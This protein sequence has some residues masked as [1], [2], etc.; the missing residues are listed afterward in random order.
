MN[1]QAIE[2][3]FREGF[4]AGMRFRA[5]SEVG[6]RHTEGLDVDSTWQDFV[7]SCTDLW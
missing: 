5:A 1:K 3:A 4:E 2:N 7:D 6:L